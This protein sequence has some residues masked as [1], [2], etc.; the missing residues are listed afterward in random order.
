MIWKLSG[1]TQDNIPFAYPFEDSPVVSPFEN[2]DSSHAWPRWRPDQQALP[3]L[4]RSTLASRPTQLT[5]SYVHNMFACPPDDEA[6]PA[7]LVRNS[8]LFERTDDVV[9]I[10]VLN[11]VKD[12]NRHHTPRHPT[13]TRST[14]H[15]HF[16]PRLQ[17]HEAQQETARRTRG[18]DGAEQDLAKEREGS[19]E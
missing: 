12:E 9:P 18:Q 16:A 15:V 4:R 11:K 14:K 1:P 6:K 13:H 17:P 5:R 19:P 3:C 7:P 8:V 2:P 10:H